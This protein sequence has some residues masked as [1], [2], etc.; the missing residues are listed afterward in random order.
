MF[1]RERKR[2]RDGEKERMGDGR[3]PQNIRTQKSKHCRAT[4]LYLYCAWK[5]SWTKEPADNGSE[6]PSS[7]PS[8]SSIGGY[9]NVNRTKDSQLAQKNNFK[10]IANLILFQKYILILGLDNLTKKISQYLMRF[11]DTK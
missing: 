5:S 4:L 1:K 7:A 2:G 3:N 10:T 6:G 11:Q 9:F 8:S